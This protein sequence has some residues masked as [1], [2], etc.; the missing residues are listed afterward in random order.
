MWAQA[1]SMRPLK[2]RN[3]S[4]WLAYSCC[5][6]GIIT[7]SSGDRSGEREDFSRSHDLVHLIS[8]TFCFQHRHNH[9]FGQYDGI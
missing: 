3:V 5:V 7:K 9:L 2:F 4:G 1:S 6:L 8:F